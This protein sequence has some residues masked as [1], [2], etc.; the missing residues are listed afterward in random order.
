[1]RPLRLYARNFIGLREVNISF[2]NKGLFVIQ[3][4]NGAGKSS[5]LEAIYFALFGKTIRH[6]RGYEGVVNKLSSENKALV[7]LE[8]LHH[9]KRWRVKLSLILI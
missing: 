2:E 1:M 6:D 5:I 4:P 8:F 3:G 7:E 9:G